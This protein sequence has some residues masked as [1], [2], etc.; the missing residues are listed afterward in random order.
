VGKSSLL[1][2][3]VGR[4]AIARTSKS[5][6]KTRDCNVYRVAEELYLVDLPGYG[7]ARVSHSERHRFSRLID[8]YLETRSSLAGVVWLLDVRR[9]PAAPDLA[10][11]DKLAEWEVPVL[12][13]ITKGDKLPRARRSRQM[14]TILT[15]VGLPE[16]QAVLTSAVTREGLDDLRES[17]LALAAEA[18][19]R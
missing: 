11:A 2:A 9:D 19:G 18:H 12:V 6:G 1:N 14:R 7:Y 3:L 16:E 17:I 15:T 5:P 13:A 4:K 10:L 8:R